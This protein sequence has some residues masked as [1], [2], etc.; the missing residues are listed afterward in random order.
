M[1]TKT[2]TH[3]DCM[4]NRKPA[5]SGTRRFI[6]DMLAGL[7]VPAL[8]FTFEGAG[9]VLALNLFSIVLVAHAM[10][11]LLGRSGMP[12]MYYLNFM[13][14]W[15]AAGNRRSRGGRHGKQ[16]IQHICINHITICLQVLV[17]LGFNDWRSSV[18]EVTAGINRFDP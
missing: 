15:P 4:H 5:S 18:A 7:Q 17:C 11:A 10:V 13:Q 9:C 16:N 2:Q 12:T 3:A 1:H 14:P 8:A 6:G